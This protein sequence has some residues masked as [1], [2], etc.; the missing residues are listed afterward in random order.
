MKVEELVTVM[1][2]TT[3]QLSLLYGIS[4][5]TFQKW[6]VPYTTEIGERNGH[7]YSVDQARIIFGKL[8]TPRTC[9]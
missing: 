8:G 5:R 6:L 7:Y 2:Y 9:K 3:K 1:P 4:N